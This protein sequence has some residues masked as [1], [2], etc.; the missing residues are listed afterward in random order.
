[1]AELHV[2]IEGTFEP[3]LIFKIGERNGIAV[4]YP[5]VEALRDAYNFSDLQSFLNLY[6]AGMNVLRVEQDYYDLTAAYL[7]KAKAKGVMIAVGSDAHSP[8]DQGGAFDIVLVIRH[9]A[10]HRGGVAL[11]RF[12][13][14]LDP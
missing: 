11:Q 9:P 7:V 14:R 10:H 1:M 3:E 2:H 4:P 6:Y 8:R 5:S 12:G 13:R